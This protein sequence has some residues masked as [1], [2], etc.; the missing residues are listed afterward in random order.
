[1]SFTNGPRGLIP[2]AVPP[3]RIFATN[4]ERLAYTLI[5]PDVGKTFY[6]TQ[7]YTWWVAVDTGSGYA[8]HEVRRP[9]LWCQLTDGQ[10]TEGSPLALTATTRTKITNNAATSIET[11]TT[12]EQVWNVSTNKVMA[13]YLNASWLLRVDYRFKPGSSAAGQIII[14]L[15]IGGSQ[16]IIAQ[17][18]HPIY[19]GTGVEQ[20]GFFNLPIYQGATFVANG[21]DLHFTSEIDGD[22]YGINFVFFSLN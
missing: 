8:Y 1:M 6:V 15:D 5:A 16:G 17:D 2:G 7:D 21:G 20:R 19:K 14:D 3:W 11:Q 18:N 12:V 9:P 22:L 4:A 10:Y 13:Q